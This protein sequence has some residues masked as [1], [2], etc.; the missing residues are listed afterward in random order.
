MNLKINAFLNFL[1]LII[2]IAVNA[3]ANILPINGL[4]TGQISGFY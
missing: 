3:L 1:G 2:V 4:N